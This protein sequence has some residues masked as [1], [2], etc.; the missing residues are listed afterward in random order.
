MWQESGQS[1]ASISV[2]SDGKKS[3]SKVGGGGVA[4]TLLVFLSFLLFLLACNV[5][6]M[7]R[8]LTDTLNFELSEAV[9]PPWRTENRC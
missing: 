1:D 6:I 8:A 3:L 9:S 7:T 4:S 2:V 5:E